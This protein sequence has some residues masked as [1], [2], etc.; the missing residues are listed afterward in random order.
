MR[1]LLYGGAFNPPHLGHERLLA[2]AI[3][4]VRPDVT[5]VVP[6]EVSPH[7]DNADVSFFDR[8][9]MCRTFLTCGKIIKISGMENSGRRRKSYTIQTV[10]RLRRR[11]PGADVFLLVGSD[12]LL[13]FDTWRLYRRLLSMVTLV[14]APRND[15]DEHK[16]QQGIAA[17]EKLGGSV[18]RLELAPLDITSTEVRKAL[19]QGDPAQDR[20]SAFVSDYAMQ[21][22]LYG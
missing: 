2:G 6:S 13:S 22:K 8:A 20:V 16:I 21:R 1:I 7:K 15:V 12:M 3:A 10:K 19:A 9:Y 17:V 18:L 14:A 4:A 5:L 11:Y